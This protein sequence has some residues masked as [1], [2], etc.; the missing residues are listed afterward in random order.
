MQEMP[1]RSDG[2][3]RSGS[4]ATAEPAL[5]ILWTFPAFGPLTAID[6]KVTI[7]RSVE[8]DYVLRECGLLTSR[9]H[10]EL[11]PEGT[12]LRVRDLGTRNGTYVN[13][14]A[15]DATLLSAGDVV[16]L[17][18]WLGIVRPVDHRTRE[19]AFTELADG[20]WGSDKLA[21]VVSSL[22]EVATSPL[23]VVIEGA[24]GTGKEG[25]AR[26]VHAW[27]GRKGPFQAINCATITGSLSD[28]MLFGHTQGAFTGA[29]QASQGH[30]LA[31][32]R[33]TLLL[34]E[35]LET[36]PDVQAKLL[37]TIQ[38]GELVPVGATKPLS[39]DVR[40]IVAT[41]T[42]LDQAWGGGEL[43]ADLFARLSGARVSVPSL[44]ERREDVPAL[45]K[46]F[47]D[48]AGCTRVMTA[49]LAEVLCLYSWP[50]NV[51][52]LELLAKRVS[53]QNE[54]GEIRIQDVQHALLNAEPATADDP[55]VDS[56]DEEK[57]AALARALSEVGGHF[58]RACELVGLSR[59][60]GSRLKRKYPGRLPT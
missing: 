30:L 13:G 10:A 7:G 3:R 54:S 26:A 58:T 44:R 41:Q 24:T 9:R 50:L 31:A 43:R 36:P 52:Q 51:R 21:R 33:G 8:C 55:Q 22:R 56:E 35:F 5:G 23:P 18:D 42:P 39:L 34:D 16:R 59:F 6:R 53:L 12:H 17:G 29:R 11:E 27:S 15:I 40:I 32:N 46:H 48:A 37:R 45:F 25:L 38:F 49:Q 4:G 47:L 2:A 57:L 1:T 28:A 20:V 14:K 19:A 60:Q